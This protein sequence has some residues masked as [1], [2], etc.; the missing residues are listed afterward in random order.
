MPMHASILLPV[1]GLVLGA[2]LPAPIV[3][4][5]ADRPCPCSYPGG[6]AQQGETVCLEVDGQ[7]RLARCVMVLNNASWHFLDESCTP[8]ASSGGTQAPAKG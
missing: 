1:V 2:S 7:H 4:V 6:T 5:H 8:T 3:Q